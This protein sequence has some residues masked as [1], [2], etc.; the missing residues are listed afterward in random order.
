MFKFKY[1]IIIS[2]VLLILKYTLVPDISMLLALS[3]LMIG[4]SWNFIIGFIEGIKK[5]K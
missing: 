4:F 5:N 1:D 2:L 3:P